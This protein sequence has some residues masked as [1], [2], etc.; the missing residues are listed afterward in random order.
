MISN[1]VD[2]AKLPSESALKSVRRSFLRKNKPQRSQA[3]FLY[4]WLEWLA[5]PMKR[6]ASPKFAWKLLHVPGHPESAIFIA[7]AWMETA[8]VFV[9]RAQTDTD[10]ADGSTPDDADTNEIY[11]VSDFTYKTNSAKFP[12]WMLALAGKHRGQGTGPTIAACS[13]PDSPRSL[14][15][16]PR[17]CTRDWKAATLAG[18][19]ANHCLAAS[20][21]CFPRQRN[22]H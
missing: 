16:T 13:C 5:Q 18:R 22:R 17:Y 4:E 8:K 3:T 9:E 6:G 11:G 15:Q 20:R 14:G 21:S 12:M 2:W 10:R 7:P 1:G 19:I